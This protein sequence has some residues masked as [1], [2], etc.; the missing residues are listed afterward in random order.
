M[1]RLALATTLFFLAACS[2]TPIPSI[3]DA[4]GI[5]Q[6]SLT[7]TLLETNE[8]VETTMR[9]VIRR[10]TASEGY[11][12]TAT[13]S[14]VEPLDLSCSAIRQPNNRLECLTVDSVFNQ[15][16]SWKGALSTNRFKGTLQGDEGL[17]TIITGSFNLEKQ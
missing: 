13:R 12:G 2:S 11:I 17:E 8:T 3:T 10:N 16:I 4:T 14:G 7:A 6:G 9:L 1:K 5:F 15:T